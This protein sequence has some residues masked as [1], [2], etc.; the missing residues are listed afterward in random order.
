MATSGGVDVDVILNGRELD[1]LLKGPAGPVYRSMVAF[2]DVV[3]G[4]AMH[5]CPVYDPPDAF[6][7]SHRSRRPGTLRDSIVKRVVRGTDGEVTVLVGSDDPVALWV[8]E[9]TQP[10]A[11][12]RWNACDLRGEAEY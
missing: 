2:G 9:G 4:E 8:H 12:A 10:Q 1:A 6:S 7:A 11:L 3:K 5:E